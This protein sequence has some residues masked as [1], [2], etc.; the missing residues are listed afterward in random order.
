MATL[1]LSAAG[2]ALG[3]GVGGSVLGV[4][5]MVIGRALGATAG[6]V[7]DSHLLGSGSEPVETGR[8]D[9]YRI[10]ASGEGAPVAE[11]AGRVRLRGQVIWATR[12]VETSTTS[13]GGGKGMP[14]ATP[15]TTSYAYSVSLALALCQGEILHVGRIWADGRE[16]SPDDLNMRIYKG[17]E[18]QLPDAKI[19]AVEGQGLAPAYRGTAYVVIEDLALESFGN[20][21][22]QFSFEVVRMVRPKG[23]DPETTVSLGTKAVAL[24]PGTGDYALATTPVHTG[25]S[26]GPGEQVAVNV[27]TPQGGTDFAVS[28][29][30][31]EG[32]LPSCEAVSLVVSW[33]GDDLRCGQCTVRPKVDQAVSD[34]AEMPWQV[35]GLGRTTA[36]V[37]GSGS[38]GGVLYGSTPCDASVIEAIRHLND[39]GQA[40]MFYPFVLME[41]PEGNS[42]P[43][44]YGGGDSQP[45][46]PWRGRITLDKAPGQPGS[47]DGTAAAADQV[48]A[49]FGA[50]RPEDFTVG[51]GSVAYTGP[52]DWGYRRFALHQAHLCAQAGG[53][54]AFCV[55]SELRG[56]TQIRAEDGRFPAVEALIALVEDVRTI[57]GPDTRIGYAADW[58]EYYGYHPLDGSGDVLFHLDPLWS[59]PEVGFVGIDNY[60][61]L[62]DW[63][64]GADHADAHWGAIHDRGYLQANIEGGEGY[65]WYY[66][67]EQ[68]RDHQLR[69][70]ITDGLHGED[71]IF[72]YKDV[73]SWWSLPHHERRGGVRQEQPTGWQPRS[74]PVWFTEIGCPAVDKGTNQPN[75]F[76][77]ARSSESAL[78]Y[79]STGSRD[80]L[81]QIRYLEALYSY[82]KTAANN[83]YSEVYDGPMVDMDRAFVWA[84]DARPY[85][86]FPALGQRWADALNY[87]R[88]HWISG[89]ST[90]Q[91][92]AAVTQEICEQSGVEAHDTTGLH[93]AVR[94]VVSEGAG[95]GRARLQPLMLGY[96][97]DAA[98]RD[99]RIV[100]RN[101]RGR[102]DARLGTDSLAETPDLA[103]GLAAQRRADAETAGRLQLTYIEADGDLGAGVAEAIMPDEA[104]LAVTRAELPLSL[105]RSEARGLAARWL[106]EARV[107]RDSVRLGLPPSKA[108]IGAGDVIELRPEGEADAAAGTGALYRID[109]LE[110]DGLRRAEATRIDPGLYRPIPHEDDRP[111]LTEYVAPVPV[112]PVFMDLPLLTGDEVPHA[113]HLAVTATPWP[114]SAAAYASG[115]A[116]GGFDLKAVLERRSVIGKSLS[117]L[118]RAI[119]GVF[120]RGAPWRVQVWGG[121]LASASQGAVLNGAN[122]LAIGSGST[123]DWEVVQFSDAVLVGENTYDLSGLLR[124]QRGTDGIMP[125]AWEEG[126]VV[127]LLDAAPTQI[128]LGADTRGLAR[129]YRVGPAQRGPWDSTYVAAQLAFDGVG[130]RPY[131]PAHLR[132]RRDPATGDSA[133]SWTRRTRIA[134]DSWQGN[135]VP[136]GEEREAYRLEIRQGDTVLRQLERDAP[137]FTYSAAQQQAD[138]VAPGARL[139]VAQISDAF[140]PGPYRSISLDD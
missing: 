109:R 104:G 76:L 106:A 80:D 11:A 108:W 44:P 24:I 32:E 128:D 113:P 37:I 65:D 48:A 93:A 100:F 16:L 140:G 58:S 35:S 9:R 42:L 107:A 135:E 68:A 125:D 105:S 28:M 119:P 45:A 53:V 61:P 26:G 92:L 75:K 129:H 99:G 31:L 102:A 13:G 60:M 52:E 55:A 46:L 137:D 17:D 130:L 126:S 124:G 14:R 2:A 7:I 54:A 23:Q 82:W 64:D 115:Q 87:G 39:R 41:V 84:W 10:G 36:G 138:G 101:R 118:P 59:H 117:V 63:R 66:P 71:W 27:S 19:E 22:P 62:S 4:S 43:D 21:V 88:G 134:G 51:P 34:G 86:A 111:R 40:V 5:S 96:G 123:G 67:T 136:L 132:K 8:I 90:V 78:P 127:V 85:P 94:G 57:L 97:V 18:A 77:D 20:R 1:V 25:S 89:R 12:F 56:L 3:A 69:A 91:D 74:K 98:E 50:A 70:P 81:I 30:T 114:G 72:R 121:D 95:S 103:V 122:A 29:R 47:V 83:P 6:R 49:F 73:R 120:T 131:A 38:D 112:Y 110:A 133:V 116:E 15:R 139:Y 79:H 33:F